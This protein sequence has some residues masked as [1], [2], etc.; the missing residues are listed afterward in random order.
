MYK[1]LS[2]FLATNHRFV[3]LLTLIRVCC[4]ELYDDPEGV[5]YKTLHALMGEMA[6]LFTDDV[7]NIGSDETAAKGKCTVN[8]TFA[9]ERRLLAAIENDFKKTPE[10]CDTSN[11]RQ[12]AVHPSPLMR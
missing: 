10:G 3:G 11:R 9:I 4:A 12:A 8:S 7:F 2:V 1:F 6:A 5:T